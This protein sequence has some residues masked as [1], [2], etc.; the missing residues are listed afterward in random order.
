MRRT[1]VLVLVLLWGCGGA[2]NSGSS[3]PAA[4]D[5]SSE[6]DAP[7][8]S[9]R[10]DGAAVDTSVQADAGPAQAPGCESAEDCAGNELCACDGSC[11]PETGS[12]CTESKNC[13]SGTWCDTCSQQCEETVGL[14]EPCSQSGACGFD[15]SCVPLTSGGSFCGM[16]C[17]TGAGCPA[18]FSCEV[19]TGIA[20]SQCVPDSGDCEALGLCEDSGDCP[21]GEK[22]LQKSCVQ[23]CFNDGGCPLDT[24]CEAADCVPPCA[25]DLDCQAPALCEPDGHCRA[26]GSCLSGADCEPGDHCDKVSGSCEPGC[27]QDADCQDAAQLCQGEQCV[28]KGC[29]HNYQCGFGEECEKVLGEC[30]PT[31][32]PHCA[33]CDASQ[34]DNSAACG[35]TEALCAT[36]SD[37]DETEQGDFCFL[38]CADD[39]VDKCPQGYGCVHIEVPDAG[40]DGWYCTRECWV[41]AF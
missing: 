17:L 4:T 34:E 32:D 33:V 40:I 25:T 10:G 15:G 11:V 37:A 23:G 24:V 8:L 27:L 18:G 41:E 38:T 3:P 39:E 20:T 9:T 16:N 14:C 19:V 7:G 28:P 31:P 22:C 12:P 1:L 13:G 5:A 29:L 26:P 21:D 6:L 36:L 35:S 2:E 30:L